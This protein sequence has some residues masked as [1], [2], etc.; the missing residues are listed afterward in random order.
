MIQAYC[1]S[2]FLGLI[3]SNWVPYISTRRDLLIHPFTHQ[4]IHLRKTS[5]I[6]L[7]SSWWW[8][9]RLIFGRRPA[10]LCDDNLGYGTAINT[11]MLVEYSQGAEIASL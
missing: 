6:V 11:V 2:E 10:M 8:L 7:R 3:P 1:Q 4:L 5:T 9:E